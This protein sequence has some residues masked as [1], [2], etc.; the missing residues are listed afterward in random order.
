MLLLWPEAGPSFVCLGLN[1]VC[2]RSCQ[3]CGQGALAREDTIQV[4]GKTQKPD[5]L[6]VLHANLS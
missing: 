6:Q 5:Q 1:P 3:C 2:L 4:R